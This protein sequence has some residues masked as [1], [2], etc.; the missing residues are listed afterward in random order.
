MHPRNLVSKTKWQ[1]SCSFMSS[2]KK[3]NFENFQRDPLIHTGFETR[4]SYTADQ[5]STYCAIERQM[6][7]GMLLVQ[8]LIWFAIFLNAS[9]QD[10]PILFSISFFDLGLCIQLKLLENSRPK[11]CCLQQNSQK[12]FRL[13]LQ[14][15]ILTTSNSSR[16]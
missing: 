13:I 7:M 12:F 5:R 9:Y 3:R 1:H 8:L 2:I 16:S 4:T 14:N 10:S 11:A 6:K 15:M